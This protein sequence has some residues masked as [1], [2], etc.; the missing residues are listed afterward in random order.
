MGFRLK[1]D[2]YGLLSRWDRQDDVLVKVAVVATVFLQVLFG[3]FVHF[4]A[5]LVTLGL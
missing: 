5:T 3:F 2:P 4:G 1:A